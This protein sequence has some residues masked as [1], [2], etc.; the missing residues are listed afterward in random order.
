MSWNKRRG[1]GWF[2]LL[3]VIRETGDHVSQD[4]EAAQKDNHFGNHNGREAKCQRKIYIIIQLC[5]I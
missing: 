4:Q 5:I 1:D 2:T 3:I